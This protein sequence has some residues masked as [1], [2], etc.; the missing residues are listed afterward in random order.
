[1]TNTSLPVI[2]KTDLAIIQA[3]HHIALSIQHMTNEDIKH[4]D[5]R[6]YLITIPIKHIDEANRLKKIIY[7]KIRKS[8]SFN[9]QDIKIGLIYCGDVEGTRSSMNDLNWMNPHIHAT[10]F[11]PRQVAPLSEAEQERMKLSIR[12]ELLSL[13]EVEESVRSG[14][15]IDVRKYDSNQASLFDMASYSSKADTKF[16]HQKA[17]KFTT[18]TFPYDPKS[19][20]NKVVDTSNPDIQDLLFNLHLFPEN[21][22]SYP[23]LDRM[24]PMQTHY[25]EMYVNSVSDLEQQRV[26]NRFIRLVS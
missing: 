17:D 24:I 10:M 20:N 2:T 1:M 7:T 16:I 8:F 26:R 14:R 9:D 12:R 21:V 25:R 13:Y 23:R 18:W 19:G 4:I 22:F 11:L 5:E 15:K 3:T 6:S